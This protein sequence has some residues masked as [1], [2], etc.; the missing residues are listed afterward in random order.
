EIADN[1][2][3]NVGTLDLNHDGSPIAHPGAMHL[4]QRSG[5]QWNWIELCESLRDAH[6]QFAGDY[7]FDFLVREGF[8]LIL[9]SCQGIEIW[10][11]KKIGASREYLAEFDEG[12]SELLE[13]F[14]EVFCRGGAR[15]GRDLIGQNAILEA[16]GTDQ[17]G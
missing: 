3:A 1:E 16:G 2:F 12:G 11:R 9:Q 10:T 8:D 14:G 13:V 7:R 5:R 15:F 4:G 6:A 17:I